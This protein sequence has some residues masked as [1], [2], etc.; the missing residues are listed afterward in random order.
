MPNGERVR[1]SGR[2]LLVE[3]DRVTLPW[4]LACRI[5][6]IHLINGLAYQGVSIQDAMRMVNE[7]RRGVYNEKIKSVF[8]YMINET[9]TVQLDYTRGRECKRVYLGAVA[10][11]EVKDGKQGAEVL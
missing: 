3:N 2:S 9:S 7:A 5:M 8:D 6:H 11:P 4:D 10:L 1:I